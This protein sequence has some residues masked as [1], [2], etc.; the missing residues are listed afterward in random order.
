MTV[1][2]HDANLQDE[3]EALSRQTT[4]PA[5]GQR[6]WQE[7]DTLGNPVDGPCRVQAHRDA[8][9]DAPGDAW[10]LQQQADSLKAEVAKD[11]SAILSVTSIPAEDALTDAP[12]DLIEV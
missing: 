10:L 7:K 2:P 6:G 3:P 8:R 4:I 1:Q 12:L 5:P 9:D 11:P